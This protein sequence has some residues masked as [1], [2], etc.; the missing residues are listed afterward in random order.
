MLGGAHSFI[1]SLVRLLTRCILTHG[2][3]T[4]TCAAA[5]AVVVGAAAA[6]ID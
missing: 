4:A 3:E 5:G 6:S 1:C 2:S